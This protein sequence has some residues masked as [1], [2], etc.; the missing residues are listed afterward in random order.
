M[1]EENN[2]SPE[3]TTNF[4]TNIGDITKIKGLAM[5]IPPQPKKPAIQPSDNTNGN[6][7]K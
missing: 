2:K 7:K 1:S 4:N 6:D 5:E 3:G